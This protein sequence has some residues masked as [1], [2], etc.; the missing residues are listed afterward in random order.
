MQPDYVVYLKSPEHETTTPSVIC[1]SSFSTRFRVTNE[2]E[3]RIPIYT[4]LLRL[5]NRFCSQTIHYVTTLVVLQ[6]GL[7]NLAFY[8]CITSHS[9]IKHSSLTRVSPQQ[10]T[11]SPTIPGPM[12][13]YVRVWWSL[14]AKPSKTRR[15]P[16]DVL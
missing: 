8:V 4:H 16:T 1:S 3:L 2:N 5:Y 6:P 11:S 13:P 7:Y 9:C 10:V 14:R 12:P 15:R